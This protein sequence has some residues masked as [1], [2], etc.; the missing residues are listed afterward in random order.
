MKNQNGV[1]LNLIFLKGIVLLIVG[2]ILVIFPQSTLSMLMV[3]I[4]IYW[5]VDGIATIV[6]AINRKESMSSWGVISGIIG[7][8][9]GS[10]VLS[11]PY[12]TAVFTASFF[13][14]FI[15]ISAL[16]YGFSGLFSGLKFPKGTIGKQSMIYG[17]LFSIIFGIALISSPYFSALTV[18]YLIGFVAII[19]GLAILFLANSIRKKLHS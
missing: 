9:A 16:V 15:G 17:G 3:L 6:R 5:L 14:W 13:M 12:L 4:G 2:L 11:K 1:I 8:V 10:V 19:G 18:V 7:V